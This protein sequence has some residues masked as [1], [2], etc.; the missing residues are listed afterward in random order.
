MKKKEVRGVR[1]KKKVV[2]VGLNIIIDK[3]EGGGG[4]ELKKGR[5]ILERPRNHI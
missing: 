4:R 2:G 5:T 1:W 3:R